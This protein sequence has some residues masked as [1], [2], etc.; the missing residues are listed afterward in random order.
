MFPI[1]IIRLWQ[2]ARDQK[3]TK[4]VVVWY[5]ILGFAGMAGYFIKPQLLIVVIAVSLFEIMSVFTKSQDGQS[6]ISH[7]ALSVYHE[8]VFPEVLASSTDRCW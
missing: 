4:C 7:R 5:I 8:A 2:I 1:L 3:S 6:L